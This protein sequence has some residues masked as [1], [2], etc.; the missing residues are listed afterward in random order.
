M[1]PHTTPS[2]RS[3]AASFPHLA[4]WLE[5][6]AERASVKVA[7]HAMGERL[8]LWGVPSETRADAVLILS[9]LAT[10]AVVHTLSTRILC[11]ITLAAGRR[12]RI[13]AHDHDRGHLSPPACTPGPE[14]ENGRGLM[15]VRQISEKWG[16]TRSVRTGGNAVWATLLTSP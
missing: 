13:E 15:L 1:A 5:L 3:L 9:E 8:T 6:P 7:R 2:P 12:L 10:N 4:H 11:G 14:D 16:V